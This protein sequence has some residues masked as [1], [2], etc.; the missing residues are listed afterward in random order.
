MQ[1]KNESESSS[2][3]Y[4]CTCG[5]SYKSKP[6]VYTHIK[7]KHNG[8]KNNFRIIDSTN[9]EVDNNR[10]IRLTQIKSNEIESS[11]MTLADLTYIEIARIIKEEKLKEN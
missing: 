8:D 3:K 7:N 6:A 1:E 5:K 2:F 10:T 9:G 11:L 4:S